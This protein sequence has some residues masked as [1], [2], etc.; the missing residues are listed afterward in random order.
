MLISR[1]FL[2]LLY[3]Y[4]QMNGVYVLKWQL[5]YMLNPQIDLRVNNTVI[6]DQFL[7]VCTC[8][9]AVFG[10]PH[11]QMICFNSHLFLVVRISAT[12]I[13][14]LKNLQGRCVMIWTSQILKLGYALYTEALSVQWNELLIELKQQLL[15]W[16]FSMS[17][18]HCLRI[19][20]LPNCYTGWIPGWF[21]SHVFSELAFNFIVLA[22]HV[23]HY[24]CY[25]PFL[26]FM[27]LHGCRIV[28]V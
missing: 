4:P 27:I 6:R 7:W 1:Q 8:V 21:F 14:T 5:I 11:D 26:L 20:I 19:S 25:C 2:G 9:F 3:F 22:S 12:L 18:G 28:M 23:K 15:W 24:Y 16:W 10:S 13:V 17:T